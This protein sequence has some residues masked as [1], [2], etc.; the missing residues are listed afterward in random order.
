MKPVVLVIGVCFL[1]GMWLMIGGLMFGASSVAVVGLLV[2]FASV[3]LVLLMRRE[4]RDDDQRLNQRLLRL[5]LRIRQRRN[6]HLRGAHVY[7][8]L[9]LT[10]L[11]RR[12]A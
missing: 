9:R 4:C 1:L 8:V 11:A 6:P 2:A 10:G 3:P 7:S 5:R 12:H